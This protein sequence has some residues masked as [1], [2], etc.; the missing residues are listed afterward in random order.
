M[1][2]QPESPVVSYMRQSPHSLG[3]LI[4]WKQPG[5]LNLLRSS[6]VPTRWGH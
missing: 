1:E 3:T 2:T 5:F 4:E 6:R